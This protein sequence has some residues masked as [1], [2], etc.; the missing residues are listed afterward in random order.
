MDIQKN[1]LLKEHTALGVGGPARYFV[2]ACTNED[3][4]ESYRFGLSKRIPILFLGKGTNILASD[5]GFDGLVIK[6]MTK[7]IKCCN[8]QIC[9]DG[10]VLM[11]DIVRYAT[12][13]KI[14]LEGFEWAVGLPGTVAGAIH[15]NSGRN[16]SCM[17]DIVDKVEYH[18]GIKFYVEKA[19]KLG[20]NYRYSKFHDFLVL[21]TSVI[22][23]KMPGCKN[24]EEMKEKIKKLREHT[25]KQ[26][27]GISAGCIFKNPVIG[28]ERISAG[29][30]IELAG[31]KGFS[32]PSRNVSD[33]YAK[34]SEEHGNF[35]LNVGGASA[36]HF[37]TLIF[38]VKAVVEN[39]S[40]EILEKLSERNN[41]KYNLDQIIRLKEEI[42]LFGRF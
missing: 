9:A 41:K 42:E 7:D 17:A 35:F 14:N 18:D 3:L 34:I 10:G 31:Y 30:I 6:V 4:I 26:P 19:N 40:R 36:F 16:N 5:K 8:R 1:V 24:P 25:Q 32:F 28:K 37:W 29:L 13:P 39:K 27:Q 2:N 23:K 38:I 22:F 33:V 20:F 21:I 12:S 15:N 11:S